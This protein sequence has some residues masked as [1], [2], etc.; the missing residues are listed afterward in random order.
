MRLIVGLLL[1][2]SATVVVK[3][4]IHAYHTTNSLSLI[5]KSPLSESGRSFIKSLV[6]HCYNN[7]SGYNQANL[8]EEIKKSFPAIKDI[9]YQPYLTSADITLLMHEPLCVLNTD[10]VILSNNCVLPASYFSAS[11]ITLLPHIACSLENNDSSADILGFV[12]H[13]D[14]LF[15]NNYGIEFCD[16][17]SVFVT[18]K[19]DE[20][21]KIICTSEQCI[22]P[23]IIAQCMR[24]KD[25]IYQKNTHDKKRW[26][27]DVRF[28]DYIVAYNNRG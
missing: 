28:A 12:T 1:L 13:H 10:L 14:K 17:H 27:M 24:V 2:C 23:D 18:K 3:D 16:K 9:F 21:L 5:I 6:M 8:L 7:N 20:E 26:M 22:T 4:K 25:Y 15:F 19:N 11:C